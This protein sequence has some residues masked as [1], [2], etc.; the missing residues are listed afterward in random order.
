MASRSHSAVGVTITPVLTRFSCKVNF[1]LSHW[2]AESKLPIINQW[3][4]GTEL[5]GDG[6]AIRYQPTSAS[7]AVWRRV[8][9]DVILCR[10]C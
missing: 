2:S 10:K 1:A 3:F 6:G 9:G 5:A 4:R 7:A 8:L